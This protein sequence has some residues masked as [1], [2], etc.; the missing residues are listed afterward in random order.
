MMMMMMMM[1]ITPGDPTNYTGSRATPS[2]PKTPNHTT[3]HSRQG[4]GAPAYAHEFPQLVIPLPPV[5]R[6]LSL[7]A[8][9]LGGLV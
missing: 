6:A 2:R 9:W 3:P 1:T 4:E 7:C 5:E 8:E